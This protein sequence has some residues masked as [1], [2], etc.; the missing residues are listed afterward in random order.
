MKWQ[1]KVRIRNKS[2]KNLQKMLKNLQNKLLPQQ[3]E[4]RRIK[5]LRFC[6]NKLRS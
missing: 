2:Q 5:Y 6:L 1:E 3:K 4:T